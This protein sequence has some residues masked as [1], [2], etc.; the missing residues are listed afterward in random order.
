MPRRSRLASLVLTSSLAVTLPAVTPGAA[1]PPPAPASDPAL[2]QAMARI[3]PEAVR[4]H[5]RFL[6]DDLLEGRGTG[7]RGYLLAAK[8]VAARFEALGLE[9]AGGGGSYFQTVPMQT[10]STVPARSSFALIRDGKRTELK[11]GEEFLLSSTVLAAPEA[12]VTA[13]L[14]Y[15]GFGI[16]APELGYDDYAG[17]DVQGKIVVVLS[18]APAR[19]PNDQRA[20]YSVNQFKIDGALARGAVGVIGV[21][22]PADAQRLPWVFVLRAFGA[23]SYQ[24]LTETGTAFRARPQARGSAVLHQKAAE[25]LFAGTKHSLEEVFRAAE[26]GEPLS[27]E[28]PVEAEMRTASAREKAESPNVAALLRGSDP[29]LRDEVVVLTAHLDHLG[30]GEPVDG[31]AIY[32]GAY[33][34]ASGVASLLEMANAFASLPVPPRRSVLFLAVTG[35]EHGLQGAEYFVHH[36]TVPRAALV[37]NLNVDM[38][39]MLHPL[40]D[41]VAWGAEHT[42]LGPVAQEAARRLGLSVGPDPFPEQVVFIRSDQFAFLHEGIPALFLGSGFDAGEPGAGA[43]AMGKWLQ[44]RYHQPSDDLSQTFDFEAGAKFVQVNFLVGY[45]VAQGEERPSWNPGDFFAP[46]GG[47]RP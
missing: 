17:I 11:W 10:V 31:D 7:S 6:A 22:T 16:H 8:Y 26:A 37:A 14:V 9:P 20:Y 42:S 36:P 2:D 45:L 28:L 30:I 19:F 13:P 25:A 5:L 15:A 27:F 32:N 43:V 21:L 39:M 34:N 3:R 1:I 46:K 24:W 4:A 47:G 41:I 38:F 23:P 40:R 33:D 29:K 44:T 12:E 35:E 18:G